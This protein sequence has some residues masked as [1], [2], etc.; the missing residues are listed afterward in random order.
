M[1]RNFVEN[2]RLI[3]AQ[4]VSFILPWNIDPQ[5]RQEQISELGR[6]YSRGSPSDYYTIGVAE[7]NPPELWE[8]WLPTS[9][10]DPGCLSR[11]PDPKTVTKERDENNFFVKPFFVATNFTKLLIFFFEMLKKKIWANFQRIMEL[12]TQK[13]VTKL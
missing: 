10:A 8:M 1:S 13:I 5:W 6:G 4:G 11:I 12:F 3:A 9:V 2:L 7:E